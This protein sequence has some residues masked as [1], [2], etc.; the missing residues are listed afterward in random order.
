MMMVV[1]AALLTD[2]EHVVEELVAVVHVVL[3]RVTVAHE[4]GHVT[5]ALHRLALQVLVVKR[6]ERGLDQ[7][8]VAFPRRDLV[9]GGFRAYGGGVTGS[10]VRAG[11]RAGARVSGRV[12]VRG[13]FRT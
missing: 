3:V 12:S 1:V 2:L 7:G 8:A 5:E 10:K 11:A 4:A 6:A 9:G 13:R